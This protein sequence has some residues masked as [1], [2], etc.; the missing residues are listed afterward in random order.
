MVDGEGIPKPPLSPVRLAANRRHARK[1]TGP[2]AKAG[3]RRV[4][5]NALRRPRSA[6]GTE[7]ESSHGR[8]P[9]VGMEASYSYLGGTTEKMNGANDA[10]FSSSFF[11]FSCQALVA[12]KCLSWL[13]VRFRT[14]FGLVLLTKFDQKRAAKGLERGSKQGFSESDLF[15]SCQVCSLMSSSNRRRL[16]LKPSRRARRCPVSRIQPGRGRGC[17]GYL[18]GPS[19]FLRERPSG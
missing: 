17:E 6:R 12:N 11:R 14:L 3:K 19:E 15:K 16:L 4:T 9:A 7:R 10:A 2:K 18:G 13:A 1:S 8:C 5:L